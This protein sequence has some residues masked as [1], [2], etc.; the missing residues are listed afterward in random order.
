MVRNALILARGNRTQS[1][2]SK[3]IQIDQRYLS[4]LELGER[5]PS[6]NVMA[7][8][9]RCYNKPVEELF[10]DIFLFVSTPK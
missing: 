8:I 6:A 10:Q 5:N 4:K 2:V 3:E 7:K 1:E 9:S